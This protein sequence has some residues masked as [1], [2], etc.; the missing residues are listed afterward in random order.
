MDSIEYYLTFLGPFSLVVGLIVGGMVFKRLPGFYRL[1]YLYLVVG[2]VSDVVFRTFG[3]V[4][5]FNLY[6]V[7]FY[8][9]IE[10]C[11]FS[12]LFYKYLTKENRVFL[13]VMAL[14]GSLFVIEALWLNQIT[15][16]PGFRSYS[17][18]ITDLAIVAYCLLY[19]GIELQRPNP[20]RDKLL[21][22]VGTI[23]FFSINFLVFGSINFLVNVSRAITAWILYVNTFSLAGYYSFLI[24]RMWEQSRKRKQVR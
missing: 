22:N 7:P 6:I 23:I 24:W 18:V 12:W 19:F 16:A 15:E 9:A 1:L 21:F 2:L 10:L 17:K 8:A 13:I 4:K 3:Y 5:G 14:F 11:L 20:D